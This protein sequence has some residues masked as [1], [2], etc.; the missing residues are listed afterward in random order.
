MI[1]LV[2]KHNREEIEGYVCQDCLI[3]TRVEIGKAIIDGF[4]NAMIKQEKK[5]FGFSLIERFRKNKEKV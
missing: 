1:N 3:D 4:D 2:C 5:K